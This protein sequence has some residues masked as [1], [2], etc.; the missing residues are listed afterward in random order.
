MSISIFV[1]IV[2]VWQCCFVGNVQVSECESEL[3]ELQEK[4]YTSQQDKAV[5][6]DEVGVVKIM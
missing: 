2:F 4:L 3:Q 1:L 5:L 6:Q